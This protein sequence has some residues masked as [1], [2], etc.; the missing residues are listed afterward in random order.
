MNVFRIIPQ[1]RTV[2]E[3]TTNPNTRIPCRAKCGVCA[4]KWRETGTAHV[5]LIITKAGKQVFAC[6]SC[7][8]QIEN[9]RTQPTDTAP[10]S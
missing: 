7:I 3:W 6:S 4:R 2:Q 9:E 5:N 10:C 1:F 8:E